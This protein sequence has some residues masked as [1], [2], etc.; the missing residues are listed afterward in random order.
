MKVRVEAEAQVLDLLLAGSFG[1]CGQMVGGVHHIHPSKLLLRYTHITGFLRVQ[2][3][4][5]KGKGHRSYNLNEYL[6]E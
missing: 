2:C 4:S 3:Y 1:W 6:N 5:Q